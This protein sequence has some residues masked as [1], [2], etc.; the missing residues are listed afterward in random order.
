M[1]YSGESTLILM[2][3]RIIK[4]KDDYAFK[5]NQLRSLLDS[6]IRLRGD[7]QTLIRSLLSD[8]HYRVL[9][10]W[11]SGTSAGIVTSL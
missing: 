4:K 2:I 9:R 10:L 3:L 6:V 1:I 11:V 8:E 5:T 7:V